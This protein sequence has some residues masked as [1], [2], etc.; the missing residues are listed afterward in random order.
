MRGFTE[1]HYYLLLEKLAELEHE[2]WM[3]WA[4]SIMDTE[5][6][7][8]QRRNRWQEFMRPYKELS[9][10]DKEQD[11]EWA[12]RAIDLML[13]VLSEGSKSRL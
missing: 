10:I 12:R 13:E 11:R 1:E 6:I 5:K 8:E 3:S 2:Q 7:S 9:E 4:K